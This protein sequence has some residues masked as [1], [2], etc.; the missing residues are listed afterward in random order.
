[1]RCQCES[2]LVRPVLSRPPLAPWFLIA[3]LLGPCGC[4]ALLKGEA[5]AATCKAVNQVVVRSPSQC[6]HGL[7]PDRMLSHLP[8]CVHSC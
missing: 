6:S 4:R 8:L 5:R 7:W 3:L 2:L 1:M